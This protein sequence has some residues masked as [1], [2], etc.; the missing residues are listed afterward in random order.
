MYFKNIVKVSHTEHH[1][2]LNLSTRQTA[3]YYLEDKLS[4]LEKTIWSGEL[5][6][7]SLKLASFT[8][9]QS[10]QLAVLGEMT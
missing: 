10:S 3:Y 2:I 7:I 8:G 9:A 4:S 1:I 5:S 6:I